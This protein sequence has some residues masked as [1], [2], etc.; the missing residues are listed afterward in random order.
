MPSELYNQ[1]V[2]QRGSLDN[3]IA[4]LPG[5]KG[6]HEKEARRA[7][8]RLLRE[9]LGSEV[10]KHISRY[11]KIQNDLLD[12]GKGLKFMTR[13]REVKAEIQAYHDRVVTAAPKYSGM[14]EQI[15]I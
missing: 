5:F 14:F 12:G 2:S 7:A 1:I 13:A 11:N 3:L 15:K 8:D 6:Y 4:R 10:E 9:H